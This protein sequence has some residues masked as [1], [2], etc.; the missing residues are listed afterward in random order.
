MAENEKDILSKLLSDKSTGEALIKIARQLSA[1]DSS[2]SYDNH[3]SKAEEYSEPVP[4]EKAAS[5]QRKID[6][7][8]AVK[9]LFGEDFSKKADIIINALNAAKIIVSLKL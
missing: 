9:P 6:V 5:L 7:L 2:S 3:A 8:N 4:N 1:G